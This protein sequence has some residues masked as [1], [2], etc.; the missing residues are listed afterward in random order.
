MYWGAGCQILAMGIVPMIRNNGSSFFALVVMVSG[1]L[2]NIFLD[3]LFVWVLEMGTEGAAIATILGQMVTTVL[4]VIY[5]FVRRLPVLGSLSAS[6]PWR[7]R[8]EPSASPPL[9]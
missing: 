6:F 9:D 3:Y 4:S 2:T 8:L 7:E 5:L 1:F